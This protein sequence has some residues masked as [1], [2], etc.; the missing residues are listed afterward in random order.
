MRGVAAILGG[1]LLAGCLAAPEAEP[2][3]G[4]ADADAG[5]PGSTAWRV[6][7]GAS[8]PY[9][10]ADADGPIVVA[11]FTGSVLVGATTF[12]ATGET[13]DLL[14]A[15]FDLGGKVRYVQAWGGEADEYPTAVAASPLGDTIGVVGMYGGGAAVL[16]EA[17]PLE[18]P[19]GAGYNLFVAQYGPGPAQRWGLAGDATDGLF[20]Y[21]T[22]SAGGG[23]ELAFAGDYR[24]MMQLGSEV[25]VDVAG[26]DAFVARLTPIG[27]VDVLVPYAAEGDQIGMGAVDDGLGNLLVFGTASAAFMI[28]E[29]GVAGDADHNLFVAQLDAAGGTAAWVIA[30]TG[31]GVGG[32]RGAA[33]GDGSLLLTG[34]FDGSLALGSEQL[35]ARGGSDVFLALVRP[36]GQVA[37]LRQFGGIG[38]DLPGG[39]AVA[40]DGGHALT[41]AF[42]GDAGLSPGEGEVSSAGASDIFLLAFAADGTLRWARSFGGPEDDSGLSVAAHAGGEVTLSARYRG[43]IEVGGG[44]PLPDLDGDAGAVVHFW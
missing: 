10:A 30:S 2:R 42:T 26:A 33:L 15:G 5:P 37:S 25:L 21:Y 12:T 7:L 38:D 35:D 28:D 31:G 23:G 34:W 41:G 40:P 13:S 3:D 39:I 17:P 29:F 22:L 16:G 9:L 43:A 4:G 1:L 18:A 6:P 19:G 14:I 20:P 32:L 27:E 24:S 44:E 36:D 11:G 8:T